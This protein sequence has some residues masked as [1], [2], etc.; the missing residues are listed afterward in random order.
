M[1]K[2]PQ[3]INLFFQGKQ[4][5]LALF[6]GAIGAIAN[7][8]PIDLAFNIS[9][10]IGNAAYIIAASLLPPR[11]TLFCALISVTPLYF[12]WGHPYGFLTFGL[13]A[14][15]ISTLRAR[16]WYVLTAD[17]LYWL[18]IGMSKILYFQAN[19]IMVL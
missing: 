11:H 12:Y 6:L 5:L 7:L 19:R 9:L 1:A 16:G 17:L 13:E 10:L 18:V 8:F 2:L 15:F 3:R 14:W 4:Y